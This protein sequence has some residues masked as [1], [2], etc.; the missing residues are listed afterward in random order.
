MV[1]LHLLGPTELTGSD[2][3]EVSGVLTRRKGLALLSYLAL[4]E[5]WS[6]CRRETLAGLLWPDSSE[7]RARASLSVA[8]HHLRGVL[9]RRVLLGRGNEEIG[10]D[11]DALWVDTRA[12]LEAVDSGDLREAGEL[13]RGDLLDGFHVNGTSAF[14]TWLESERRRLRLLAVNSLIGLADSIVEADPAEACSWARRA[15]RLAPHDQKAHASLIRALARSSQPA[16]ALRVLGELEDRLLTDLDLEPGAELRAL[17]QRLRSADE[18]LQPAPKAITIEADPGQRQRT[19]GS[20]ADDEAVEAARHRGGPGEDRASATRDPLEGLAGGSA[21]AS[22]GGSRGSDADRRTHIRR[23][24]VVPGSIAGVVVATVLFGLLWKDPGPSPFPSPRQLQVPLPEETPL[25]ELGTARLLDDGSGLVYAGTGEGHT[26]QSLWLLRWSS[27]ARTTA[28]AV[29]RTDD[30]LH[31]DPSPDARD[32]A[33]IVG[34]AIRVQSLETAASRLLVHEGARCCIRW[35]GDGW[36]Y[37]TA[38]DGGLRRIPEDGGVVDVLSVTEDPGVTHAWPAPLGDARHLVF[39]ITTF[40]GFGSRIA[41][42]DIRTGESTPLWDGRYPFSVG[43]HVFFSSRDGTRLRVAD[44]DGSGLGDPT[45]VL[46][47]MTPHYDEREG[48]S[49]DLSSSGD[50]FYSAD[51]FTTANTLAPVW[52]TREGRMAPLSPNLAEFGHTFRTMRLSPDERRIAF[53][54]RRTLYVGELPFGPFQP[55]TRDGTLNRKHWWTPD[56][57][58]LYYSSDRLGPF[59]MAEAEYFRVRADGL[60]DPE[61]LGLPCASATPIPD[62]S[63]WICRTRNDQPDRGNLVLWSTSPDSDPVDLIATDATEGQAVPSPDSRWFAYS[64]DIDGDRQVYVASLPDPAS[65]PQVRVSRANGHSPAWSPSTSELFYVGED[66]WMWAV[67]YASD[68][69]FTVVDRTRLFDASGYHMDRFSTPHAYDVSDDAQRFVM[70]PLRS[71]NAAPPRLVLVLGVMGE[72]EA[73]R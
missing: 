43:R 54:F 4:Q 73:M 36:L 24:I 27:I 40:F 7:N 47:D 23:W 50:L 17:E 29:P 9:G 35:H 18:S 49:Y 19:G 58:G 3:E 13:Y 67:R 30:V 52:V 56:G 71:R 6:F 44:Y 8:L 57:T 64:T 33:L 14:T 41:L 46:N 59:P 25:A 5:P 70:V 66:E 48:G 53:R 2:G 62:G 63:G 31:F 68:T 20:N 69:A 60:G 55:V 21:N 39:E 15:T 22:S 28:T 10:I 42:L 11:P 45:T 34:D 26:G 12:F 38:Q 72:I 16:A 51:G 32:V 1:K 61:P 65:S 37:F